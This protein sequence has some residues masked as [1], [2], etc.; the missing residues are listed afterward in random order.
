MTIS[1]HWSSMTRIWYKCCLGKA[2]QN[3]WN[4]VDLPLG[5]VAMATESSCRLVMGKMVKLH[6]LH[7]QWSD[8]N[9]I[10]QLW[11]FDDCL[12]SLCVPQ[13]MGI[14]FFFF[15]AIAS[16]KLVKQQQR[17]TLL[18]TSREIRPCCMP[19]EKDPVAHQRG[20]KTLLHASR[21]RPCCAP[22]GKEDPVACQ[23]R[24]TLLCT[25]REKRFCC[26]PAEKAPLCTSRERKPCLL[27]CRESP[28]RAPAGKKDPVA[29]Q[30]R[31]QGWAANS[32]PGIYQWHL[33]V[34]TGLENTPQVAN[35]GKYRQIE[36]FLALKNCRSL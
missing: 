4:Y 25:S 6:L 11:S 8:V 29:C 9:H 12:P 15:L 31:K 34:F 24:K 27:A 5:F 3:N 16:R 32:T 33:P 35:T 20:K 10:W 13:P 19:A 1:K 23:Q 21:E 2:I 30:Q 28:C 18:C 7:N 36:I 17:K 22:A 14:F 26:M